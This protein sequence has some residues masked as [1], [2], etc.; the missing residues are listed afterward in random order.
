MLMSAVD[1]AQADREDP[2]VLDKLV[3]KFELQFLS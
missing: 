2:K 1:A 3:E